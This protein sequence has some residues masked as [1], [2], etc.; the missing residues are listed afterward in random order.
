MH[1]QVE[2]HAVKIKTWHSIFEVPQPWYLEGTWNFCRCLGPVDLFLG[3][4]AGWR[5]AAALASETE[6]YESIRKS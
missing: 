3:C 6:A 2:C 1:I 5:M 4:A